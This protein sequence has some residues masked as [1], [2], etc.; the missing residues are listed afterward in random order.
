MRRALTALALVVAVSDA[1]A[2][3]VK[4]I[5]NGH[6]IE[7]SVI[8]TNGVIYVPI[9]T[10]SKA[11]GVALTIKT[12]EPARAETPKPVVAPVS[13]PGPAP[14]PAA[15]PAPANA[16][17]PPPAPVSEPVPAPA[18][19][20]VPAPAV[21][22]PPTTVLLTVPPRA[23]PA[24]S[25]KGTLT[26]HFNLFENSKP[27]PGAEVWLVK[28]AD[29]PSIAAASGGTTDE[30]ISQ[31]AVDWDAKLTDQS[32]FPHR[33]ADSRGEFAFESVAPGAYLLIFKSVRAN[34]LAERDREGKFRFKRVQVRAGGTVDAS[35][36]FGMTA[37]KD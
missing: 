13:L 26:Y 17:A 4:I 6:E 16:S 5:V 27:D 3:P 12:N 37:Y 9:D 14:V 28:E 29:V 31:R 11:L 7:T 33:I 24:P 25:I 10:L 18:P 35:F 20:S 23:V 2:T 21:A 15:E 1:Q 22:P 19:P 30:P 32:K 8:V 36:N 34:G